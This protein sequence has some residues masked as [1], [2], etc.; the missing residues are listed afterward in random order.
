MEILKFYA[1][2]CGPC[3][4][5]ENLL[6]ARDIPHTNV[7]IDTDEGE[8]LASKYGIR[9]I[10]VLLVIDNDEVVNRYVGVPSVDMLEEL[11]S[12]A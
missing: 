11:K 3:K 4:V 6:T 1:E 8:E 2:W 10:P 9:N 12:Y 5:V 7:N